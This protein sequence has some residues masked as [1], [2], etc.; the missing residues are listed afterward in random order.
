M[1]DVLYPW[2]PYGVNGMQFNNLVMTN[3]VKN[4]GITF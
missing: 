1:G 3:V 2:S 4:T